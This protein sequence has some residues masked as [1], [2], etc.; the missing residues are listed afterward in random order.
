MSKS[1]RRIK[2]RS[3][4]VRVRVSPCV[5]V[6]K[7]SLEARSLILIGMKNVRKYLICSILLCAGHAATGY[8]WDAGVRERQRVREDA[9]RGGAYFHVI[10]QN[11]ARL[12]SHSQPQART[13][14]A[15]L[16]LCLSPLH[17]LSLP[18]PPSPSLPCSITFTH[19]MC[20]M[21]F[22]YV[23]FFLFREIIYILQKLPTRY[24]L[25]VLALPLSLSL[26]LPVSLSHLLFWQPY[27]VKVE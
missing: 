21:R 15:L 17:S 3:M 8:V 22:S 5:C 18:L 13:R 9:G 20:A 14:S 16:S 26:A 10:K 19:N 12:G 6:C 7:C 24:V 4:C 2:S 27:Q 1:K 11:A 23:C 25:L